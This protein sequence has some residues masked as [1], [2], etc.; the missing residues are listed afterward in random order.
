MCQDT[1]M[2]VQATYLHI[3]HGIG[4]LYTSSG[5]RVESGWSRDGYRFI[6]K[7]YIIWYKNTV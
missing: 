1:S 5:N 6:L 2:K 3:I 4:Y 7:E